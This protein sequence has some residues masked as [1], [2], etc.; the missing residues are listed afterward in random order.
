M[1]SVAPYLGPH[2]IGGSFLEGEGFA[3]PLL[4]TPAYARAAK[5]LGARIVENAEVW[6]I[7]RGTDGRFTITT[8]RGAFRAGRVVTSAG[9]WTQQVARMV[10]IDL[11]ITGLVAQ[12][13]VTEG[14]P[15]IMLDQL[16]QHVGKGLTLKQSPQGAFIIGGGWPGYFDRRQARKSPSLDSLIGNAWV[17]TRTVPET[18][19]AQ[20][21]RSWGGMGTGSRDGLPVIGESAKVSGFYV[22]YAPLGF[23]MGP[24]CGQ[25]FAEHFLA[26]ESVAPITPYALERF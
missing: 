17:L 10:G 23:T 4:V 25:V 15:P 3:N 11:P 8:A 12:V 22:N 2:I 26:G 21:V 5:R 16:V 19:G 14:R 18:A 13:G 9:A 7:E 1:L 6:A 24:I 20:L